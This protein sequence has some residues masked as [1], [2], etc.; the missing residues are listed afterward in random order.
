MDGSFLTSTAPASPMHTPAIVP[1]MHSTGIYNMILPLFMK[2]C[3][4][5]LPCVVAHSAQYARSKETKQILFPAK[6]HDQK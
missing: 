5:Y 1:D 2:C 3:H 6:R 4:C